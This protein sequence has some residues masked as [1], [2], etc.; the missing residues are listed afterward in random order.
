[1]ISSQFTGGLNLAGMHASSQQNI[2]IDAANVEYDP[3]TSGLLATNVQDAIDELSTTTFALMQPTD[4]GLAYGVQDAGSNYSGYGLNCA[5]PPSLA[6]LSVFNRDLDNNPQL[7]PLAFTCIVQNN[8]HDD[9]NTDLRA[10]TLM[11]NDSRIN[12][13][14]LLDTTGVFSRLEANS[15]DLTGSCV[16]GDMRRMNTARALASIILKSTYEDPQEIVFDTDMFGCVYIG[17]QR[18]P[19]TINDGDVLLGE[20]QHFYLRFLNSG[21]T[22]YSV[23]YDPSTGELTWNATPGPPA[24]AL[25]TALA[26]GTSFGFYDTSQQVEICGQGSFAN[27]Q[28]VSSA[29]FKNV[30]NVGFQNFPGLVGTSTVTN[31]MFMGAKLTN[32][33]L[34]SCTNTFMATNELS[35]PAITQITSNVIIA[36]RLLGITPG[37]TQ[38]RIQNLIAI[39]SSTCSLPTGPSPR[40]WGIVLA[41]GPVTMGHNGNIVMQS[42]GGAVSFQQSNSNTIGGNIV[43]VAGPLQVD[44]NIPAVRTG[45]VALQA[46][47]NSILYPSADYQ[48]VCNATSY[49]LNLQTLVAPATDIRMFSNLVYDQN[50]RLMNRVAYNPLSATP[51]DRFGSRHWSQTAP[52]VEISVGVLS[53]ATF[54]LPGDLIMDST[55][56]ATACFQLTVRVSSPTNATNTKFYTAQVQDIDTVARTLTANVYETDITTNTSKNATGSLTVSCL[57]NV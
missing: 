27:H 47:D 9:E 20:Y 37:A 1:M 25:K 33:P 13:A 17:N 4:A 32:G 21:S 53:T 39:T 55:Y 29:T 6:S 8:S 11:I 24:V 52:V 10:A 26:A 19:L 38:T 42:S 48:F 12:S 22:L 5:P 3:A 15:V 36:P 7:A 18:A 40:S 46:G 43:L 30:S 28:G 54:N 2:P 16:V 44:Y 35:L 56:F 49:Q 14:K 57:M 45:C 31:C 34:T 23:Y 51:G 41:N 50:T